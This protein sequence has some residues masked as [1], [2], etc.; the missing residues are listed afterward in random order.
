MSSSRWLVTADWLEQHLKDSGLAVVDGSWHLPAA[1]RDAFKEYQAAHVPGAVFFDID[2]ISDHSSSLPHMLPNEEA[3]ALHMRKLGIGDGMK[4]VVYDSAGL[5]SAARVWWTFRAFGVN[6]VKIL[7]GGFPRWCA[8]G[9]PVESGPVDRKPA[10]FTARLD[11]K[12]VADLG[13]VEKSL[14]SGSAQVIDSRSAERFRGDAPEPRP[15]VRAGHMPGSLNLPYT[16]V[17]ASGALAS[18]EKIRSALKK[19]GVDP[20]KPVV[21]SCG[22]GI[23][24]A[25]MWLALETIGNP[26]QALYDG[27]WADWGSRPDKPVA[28]GAE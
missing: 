5:F 25:V 6:D 19:A 10:K 2:E 22:S 11:R 23:S 26:P 18:P 20:A 7:A 12:L 4:I 9:H 21:T 28:T 14:A 24:A 3:F 15:G 1:K 8:D 13:Q 16:D 27:S 17:V